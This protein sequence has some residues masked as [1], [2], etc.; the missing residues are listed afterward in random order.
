MPSVRTVT[1]R[2]SRSS[3]S[4]RSACAAAFNSAACWA[5]RP[6]SYARSSAR[7]SSSCLRSLA[8][9]ASSRLRS[10]RASTILT[11]AVAAVAPA[12]ASVPMAVQSSA[13]SIVARF[14]RGLAPHEDYRLAPA[15]RGWVV[16]QHSGPARQ[17]RCTSPG[18]RCLAEV[19]N[20]KSVRLVAALCAYQVRRTPL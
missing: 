14:P 20:Y 7:L 15:P 3:R 19:D 2:A 13:A 18:R 8:R 10:P 1:S 17:E 5:R 9:L 12:S 11:A 4:R 6:A 16:R